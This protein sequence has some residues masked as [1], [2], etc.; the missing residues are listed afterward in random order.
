MR[1][2]GFVAS[3]MLAAVVCAGCPYILG[4][5]GEFTT[6]G[7]GGAGASGP[8]VTTAAGPGGGNAGG[9]GGAGTGGGSGG[10]GTGGA[11]GAGGPI[12]LVTE[13]GPVHSV[14][15]DDVH[16]YWIFNPNLATSS[17]RRTERAGD[18]SAQDTVLS[19][20][21]LREIAVYPGVL[22][23]ASSGTVY[24]EP[25][26]GSSF[27]TAGMWS[28][29]VGGIAVDPV[30]IYYI[31]GDVSNYVLHSAPA[32][33]YAEFDPDMIDIASNTSNV[34][35]TF[36][37]TIQWQPHIDTGNQQLDATGTPASI[38]ADEAHV[39]WI[40]TNPNAIRCLDV[41]MGAVSGEVATG[42]NVPSSI[43]VYGDHVYWT[44]LATNR[45]AR[46]PVDVEGGTVD[47]LSASEDEPSSIAV[48]AEYVF[49]TN[50]S[51]GQVRRMLRP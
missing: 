16:V 48:D 5:E 21:S 27:T 25:L 10:A 35:W 13:G 23:A 26:D 47:V 43:A 45:V 49:W 22:A 30:R 24:R 44:E 8:G 17:V 20:V 31:D 36:P 39:C 38:A 7:V 19:E 14:A 18:G 34:Y 33:T 28:A 15:V 12:T 11:G 37:D 51:A 46:A 4:V 1:G 6:E 9:A 50:R 41:A 3:A 40:E 2:K 42:G 29:S 32:E